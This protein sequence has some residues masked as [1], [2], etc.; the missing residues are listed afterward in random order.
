MDKEKNKYFFH[1]FNQN[2]RWLTFT[3]HYIMF[4]DT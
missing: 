2:G 4:R 3:S 1:S